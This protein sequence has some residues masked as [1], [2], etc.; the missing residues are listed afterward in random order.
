MKA[1]EFVDKLCQYR[2][3]DHGPEGRRACMIRTLNECQ[4]VKTEGTG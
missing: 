1:I 4:S 2:G 3:H